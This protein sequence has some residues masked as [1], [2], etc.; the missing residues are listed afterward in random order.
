[1]Q[2][3]CW[4]L[5]R[6][7]LKD[8]LSTREGDQ[9]ML[10]SYVLGLSERVAM[11]ELQ[12]PRPPQALSSHIVLFESITL[13]K[14]CEDNFDPTICCKGQKVVEVG[15]GRAWLALRWKVW[16]K[17]EFFPRTL[18]AQS[19]VKGSGTIMEPNGDIRHHLRKGDN[20]FGLR[21]ES[22]RVKWEFRRNCLGKTLGGA[23]EAELDLIF[24]ND[25]NDE[26][27]NG[28]D[29]SNEDG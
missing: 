25:T 17:E 27:D 16:S 12:F 19:Q 26:D 5:R 15:K 18:V 29:D 24:G 2:D 4:S 3:K 6:R 7:K 21:L 14:P 23:E 10:A 11:L 22:E 20:Q 13:T 28:E 1:M 9:G 8:L